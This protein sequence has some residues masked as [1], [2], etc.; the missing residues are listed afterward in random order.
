[1]SKSLQQKSTRYFLM[2]LPFVL[3][4]GTLLFYVML[5]MHVHHM[6]EEQLGLKQENILNAFIEKPDSIAMHIIGEYD[7]VKG[8]PIPSSRLSEPRDTSIYYSDKKE[9]VAFDIWT[10]QYTV[11]GIPYQLTTYISSKEMTH[12]II[13]VFIAEIFIF[14]LLLSAIVIINRKSSGL[15]WRPFYTTMKKVKE[16]DINKNQSL[17][18]DKQTGI[19]EFNQLNQVITNLIND[20]NQAYSNQKQFVEN[21][22]HEL[23][24]PLAII[25][26]KLDL[27]IDTPDLTE[28]TAGLL[29]DITE[30]NDRL[31]Q[32]NKNLLLLTK[33]DNNQFPELTRI[34]ISNVIEK[35]L[36][37]YQAYYDEKQPLISK[38]VQRDIHLAANS[39]LME[40]LIG[41]LIN[42]SIVH[43]IPNG[44]VN[45]Q[46]N[47][48]ELIIENTGYSIAGETDQLFERFR[49]GREQS[50]TTGLGLSLVKQICQ[51]YQ[52]SLQYSY[53]EN[54]H[55]I[56]VGFQQI[57]AS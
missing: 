13:K 53:T 54:I 4:T 3:L 22:S 34:N 57:Q 42:N 32:M 35:L 31:S 47:N 25:R 8:S 17:L 30:A 11:K 38:S 20:V 19:S 9:W 26:S 43:N 39:S 15:L 21:A 37:Y 48:R 45:I 1:M 55:R 28:E 2:W 36:I 5:S 14:I 56:R 52:F 16:Y 7:I 24:T 6:Q 10:K 27:L 50:K 29:A 12:L 23:Q 49:K 18:L 41:N 44:H 40:I 51:L 46:L 33:I